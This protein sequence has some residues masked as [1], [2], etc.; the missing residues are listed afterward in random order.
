M[1]NY[2]LTLFAVLVVAFPVLAQDSP[3]RSFDAAPYGIPLPDGQG[4]MWED[5]REIH[6]VTVDFAGP[7]PAGLKFNL[8][9]W[10]SHWPQQHLPKDHEPGGGDTGWLELGNWSVGGWRVADAEQTISGKSVRFALRPINSHEYPDL[11]DYSLN[12]RFTLKIRV[13]GDQPLPKI[14]RIHAFTDST[15]VERSVRI[16]WERRPSSKFHAQA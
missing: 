10:G 8:E 12:G 1:A 3:N 4:L 15:L 2:R 6:S 13:V 16:A 9:Y 11:K 7:I 14:L 5:P